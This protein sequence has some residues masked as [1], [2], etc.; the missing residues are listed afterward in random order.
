MTSP[1]TSTPAGV[2]VTQFNT[3]P[4]TELV[5]QLAGLF[6][7][8]PL[9]VAVAEA[10]PFPS[11]DILCDTASVLLGQQDD[12]T[13]LE[14][15]NDH[16][17]IGGKVGAG[18]RSAAEQAT[19][20]ANEGENGEMTSIRNLQPT[21][22]E[23]FGWNFLIRAAGR[24]SRQILDNLVERIAHEPTEEWPIVV[25]HLDAINQLRLRDYVS[26]DAQDTTDTGVTA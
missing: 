24:D 23:K 11:V 12:D 14:S 17:P 16:P 1:V 21:Y 9:A 15:V 8:R 10:R 7:S 20:A 18:T 5:D 3:V 25:R 19:A 2:T 22:R 26:D 6:S 13:I 4:A